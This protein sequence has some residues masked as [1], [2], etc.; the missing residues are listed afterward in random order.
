MEDH[1][2]CTV[3]PNAID[4]P[5]QIVPITFSCNGRKQW[6][7]FTP[8]TSRKNRVSNQGRGIMIAYQPLE[9][10]RNCETLAKLREMAATPEM[11]AE[12]LCRRLAK[13]MEAAKYTMRLMHGG[14]WSVYIDHVGCSAS[15]SR[16]F[17]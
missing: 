12:L 1:N 14:R 10:T 3:A 15:I 9:R 13:E 5:E 16:D 11:S 2:R 4:R 17:A 8:N 7:K 6:L